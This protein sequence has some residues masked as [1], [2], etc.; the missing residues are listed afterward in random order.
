MVVEPH[1]R[2]VDQPF[3]F[4]IDFNATSR[5]ALVNSNN[6]SVL[7]VHHLEHVPVDHL[8]YLLKVQDIML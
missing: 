6:F 8:P 7:A 4:R 2:S 1:V 3:H 5:L